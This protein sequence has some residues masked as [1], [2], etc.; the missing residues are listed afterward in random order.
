MANRKGKTIP[1]RASGSKGSRKAASSG[2]GRTSAAGHTSAASTASVSA[3]G[4][5]AAAVSGRR[6]AGAGKERTDSRGGTDY[7]LIF[8][9]LVML[10]FGL[11]MLYS[12]SAYESAL[13]NDGDGTTYL[14]SQLRNTLIGLAVMAVAA[15]FPLDLLSNWFLVMVVAYGGSAAMVTSLYWIG[16]EVNGAKRWLQVGG[17][18]FQPA[19]L[20]KLAVIL[21]TALWLSRLSGERLRKEDPV[22][23]KKSLE[24]M[25]RS[26]KPREALQ[27]WR[28]F[29]LVLT[30]ALLQ[31]VLIYFISNNLSSAIIVV[32][33]AAA[34]MFV[35]SPEW[36]RYIVL[37]A[38]VIAAVIVIV[39]YV[40]EIADSGDF[41]FE[42]IRAWLDP[43]AYADDTALQTLQ[44]LY[45]I[46]SGGIFGK[47]LGQSIQ[48]L[49]TI[50]EA[51]NDMIFAIICEELGLFG[52]FSIIVLYL[53][54][55]W[56]MILIAVNARTLHESMIVI[57]VMSHIMIQVILNI[58]VVTNTIPNTGVTLPFFSYGGSAVVILLA[59]I[60]LVLNVARNSPPRPD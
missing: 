58:A 60:G 59:E 6:P 49:G 9:V 37:A 27:T 18:Q 52:A 11:V 28:G 39:Y 36:R 40:V 50:P 31:A 8:L 41:R 24:R 45:G 57:G 12:T 32:L 19:E 3:S 29:F 20:S 2:S 1:Y 34:M 35:A 42:R 14:R 56:R 55:A 30:P 15:F 16:V 26:G 23:G 5:A 33:I 17:F 38:L 46:G 21:V 4:Q 7:T 48:K 22:T 13:A 43:T 54:M 44:G 10:V 47:G 25:R 51:Q 53:I